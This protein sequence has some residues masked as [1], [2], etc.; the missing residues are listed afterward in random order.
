MDEQQLA[1]LGLTPDDVVA[2]LEAHAEQ[3]AEHGDESGEGEG[4][5]DEG[6][7]EGDLVAAGAGEGDGQGDGAPAAG[8]PAAG[9]GATGLS[10]L[11]K[12]IVEL[13]AQIVELKTGKARETE[14]TLFNALEQKIEFL[15]GE[16]EQLR[17]ALKN[18]GK[19]ATPGV[20][21][22]GIVFF[23]AKKN[24]GEFEKL[25][26]FAVEEKK[27]SKSLAFQAV[28]REQPAAYNDYL[29]RLGVKRAD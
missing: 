25:V 29:V 28:I 27:L 1:D 18:G 24:E 7:G 3:M 14:E 5:G 8:A 6:A 11:E 19:A 2:A 9:A 22:N 15:A 17:T 21:R 16:N 4:E 10:A 26:Q 20:D 23:S 13:S 12:K